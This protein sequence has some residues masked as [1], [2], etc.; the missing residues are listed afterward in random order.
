[1][2]N[3]I[4]IAFKIYKY[5]LVL[6]SIIF[7]VY[8]IIDDYEFIKKYWSTNWLKYIEGWLIYFLIYLIGLSIYFWLGTLMVAIIISSFKKFS[9][10]NKTGNTKA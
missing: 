9:I 2:K 10:R 8:I 7:W 6:Y 1:M 5:L 4:N 3:S